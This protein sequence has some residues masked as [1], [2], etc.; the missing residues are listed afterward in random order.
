MVAT[1]ASYSR[2]QKTELLGTIFSTGF[3]SFGVRDTFVLNPCSAKVFPSLALQAVNYN[4]FKFNSVNFRW[5]NFAG[6]GVL[7]QSVGI[8]MMAYNPDSSDVVPS[9]GRDMMNLEGHVSAK[10]IKDVMFSVNLTNRMPT[11]V[12]KIV[13][14]HVATL[15]GDSDYGTVTLALEGVPGSSQPIGR[16]WVE[17]DVDL[18]GAVTDSV[19][20][21]FSQLYAHYQF[22]GTAGSTQDV[23]VTNAPTLVRASPDFL[24]TFGLDNYNAQ[25]LK[26]GFMWFPPW[27]TS[28][29]YQIILKLRWT[30][31]PADPAMN[32]AL[33][34]SSVAGA[35]NT[36]IVKTYGFD[37]GAAYNAADEISAVYTAVVRVTGAGA[38]V[39][40]P[41]PTDSAG[42]VHATT[43]E[44]ITICTL[45]NDST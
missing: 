2:V 14:K 15:D 30:N 28:G 35:V 8:I 3:T 34:Y 32:P 13:P 38:V 7:A 1:P 39:K 22:N 36:Q 17:Y 44:F 41:W 31:G 20:A 10:C 24:F 29:L 9:S 45:P 11:T 42:G 26:Q 43:G 16:L 37:T 27:V 5:E 40:L 18:Y 23:F 4:Y 21:G 25:D 19:T 12:K 6:D 33:G